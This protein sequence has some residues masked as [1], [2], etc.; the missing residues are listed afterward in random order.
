MVLLC[1]L[2]IL[3]CVSAE[4]L[5]MGKLKYID[6]RDSDLDDEGYLEVAARFGNREFTLNLVGNKITCITY[7]PFKDILLFANPTLCQECPFADGVYTDCENE[8]IESP[9]THTYPPTDG[10]SST[11]HTTRHTFPS[12]DGLG[13]IEDQRGPTI[14]T[15]KQQSLPTSVTAKSPSTHTFPPTDDK[16]S[17]RH[18]TRHT[19]PSTDGLG[20]IEDQRGPTISTLKQQSLPT[21]AITQPTTEQRTF[22]TKRQNHMSTYSITQTLGKISKTT[23]KSL[24]STMKIDTP[25]GPPHKPITVKPSMMPPQLPSYQS[26]LC[27]SIWTKPQLYLSFLSGFLFAILILF[28]LARCAVKLRGKCNLKHI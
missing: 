1:L 12:T 8:N 16:S 6:C 15:L 10:K 26:V 5:F 23:P 4:C 2:A 20:T 28:C 19:F 18:T 27:D 24:K 11:R 13:T 21:S 25:S 3:A 22:K 9:S 14:S 17:T 7:N